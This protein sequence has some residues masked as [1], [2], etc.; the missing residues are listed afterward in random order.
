MPDSIP[1]SYREQ[2]F[3]DRENE[4]GLVL[5]KVRALLNKER[6]NLPH[7]TFHGP[8]G[9]G[10]SWLLRHLAYLL[11]EEKVFQDKVR[12]LYLDLAQ[13]GP[14][15]TG[16]NPRDA[17]SRI[18]EWALECLGLS[19]IPPADLDQASVWL[20]DLVQEDGPPLIALVDGLD[21]TSPQFLECLE[22]YYLVL[23]K[24]P[25]VLLVLGSRVPRPQGYTWKK[26]EQLRYR[27]DECLLEPFDAARTRKQL[28]RLAEDFEEVDPSV[29]EDVRRVGGG[30]PLSNAVLGAQWKNRAN[31]L[32][33]CAEELLEGVGQ[34]LRGYFSAICILDAFYEEHMPPLLAVYFGRERATW[35]LQS[36]RR[37]LQDMLK[38]KLVRWRSGEGYLMDSAVRAVLMNNLRE[39]RP[40]LWEQLEKA[41][42]ELAKGKAEAGSGQSPGV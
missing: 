6:P 33:R 7:T 22:S 35:D 16:S 36:C 21:K 11:Q 4:I 17:V 10:K 19:P 15:A 31:A 14:G 28:E 8:R 13:G 37:I 39:N 27:M 40:R 18:L 9:S 38:T 12:V 41:G 3:V 26:V 30:N 24:E 5:G 42:E 23:A 32:Q 25:N 29:A 2:Y 20:V 34:D 1:P